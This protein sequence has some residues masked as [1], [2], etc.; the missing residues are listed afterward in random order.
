MKD[1]ATCLIGRRSGSS[2]AKLSPERLEPLLAFSLS[3]LRVKL[4]DPGRELRPMPS[5][6]ALHPLHLLLSEGEDWHVYIPRIH[7]LR[8]LQVDS[9]A[10]S[11]LWK[12]IRQ[13][14][15]PGQ[16]TLLLV[17]A[18]GG[19]LAAHYE[20]PET[21]ALRESGCLL[22]HLGLTAEAL[23]LSYRILGPTGEPWAHQLVEGATGIFVG[24]GTALVGG[25]LS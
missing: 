17:L 19:I 9:K 6:G 5:A 7:T 11:S 24:V 10:A 13:V 20:N 14:L 25:H 3:T 1:L 2:F 21:L 23:D 16:G 12:E 8:R 15:D 18:E 22:G 4:A